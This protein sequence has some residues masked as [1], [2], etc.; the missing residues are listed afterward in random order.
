MAVLC[1]MSCNWLKWFFHLLTCTQVWRLQA[2]SWRPSRRPGCPQPTVTVCKGAPAL[3]FHSWLCLIFLHIH[4]LCHSFD[5]VL[6]VVVKHLGAPSIHPLSETSHPRCKP[7]QP[8]QEKRE[9]E[10]P[11]V[12]GNNIWATWAQSQQ[13]CQKEVLYFKQQ[14]Q[15]KEKLEDHI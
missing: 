3:S 15:N 1:L 11:A 10:R 2:D 12:T 4:C 14:P 9:N 5:V 8:V 7:S 6:N 13:F